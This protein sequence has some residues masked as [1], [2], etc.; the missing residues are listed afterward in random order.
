[1]S[2]QMITFQLGMESVYYYVLLIYRYL[3]FSKT[4]STMAGKCGYYVRTGFGV[5]CAVNIDMQL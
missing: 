1:M 4:P 5:V 2:E 3:A